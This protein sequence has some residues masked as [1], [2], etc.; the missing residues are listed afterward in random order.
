[1]WFQVN[2]TAKSGAEIMKRRTKN[3]HKA[4]KREQQG[5]EA[6]LAEE[7]APSEQARPFN[8]NC[9]HFLYVPVT[10]MHMD[11]GCCSHAMSW[12]IV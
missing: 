3:P 6:A 8:T 9:R 10:N 11:T 4:A 2:S 12:I 7:E 5:A 1:M